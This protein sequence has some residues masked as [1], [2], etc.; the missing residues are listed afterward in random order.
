MMYV[1][2]AA[3]SAVRTTN[4]KNKI[5]VLMSGGVDSSVAALLCLRAG[6]DVIGITMQ[7]T[8]DMTPIEKAKSVCEKIGIKHF[9]IDLRAVFKKEVLSYFKESYENGKTPNPCVVCNEKI[10][11]GEMFKFAKSLGADF[12]ATGHYGKI[13]IEE[14]LLFLKKSADAKKDQS[15]FLS[16]VPEEI[17][18]YTVFPLE[19]YNKE[20]VREIA[21]SF[22]L[23]PKSDKDSQDICFLIGIDYKEF[24]IQNCDFKIKA[25]N[26]ISESGEIIG[27]HKGIHNYT[28]GQRKGLGAFGHPMI[29]KSISQITG[30]ITLCAVGNEFSESVRIKNIK[31]FTVYEKFKDEYKHVKIRYSQN[32]IGIFDMQFHDDICEIKFENPQRA[33]TAGQ[34]V[35]CYHQNF[36]L[37]N[38]EIV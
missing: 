5:A 33:V 22:D 34:F 23:P 13:C 6:H 36:V 20:Q 32:E 9:F 38:G 14:G 12:I 21:H 17:L 4:N 15:Y 8:E 16:R 26:F 19:D 2:A 28:V 3:E 29:V 1:T 18:K 30:D 37:F 27:R 7:I 31:F 24:L 11:F 35:V 25:G 10:K